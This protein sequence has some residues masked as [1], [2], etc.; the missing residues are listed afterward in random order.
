[1]ITAFIPSFCTGAS[2]PTIPV[3]VTRSRNL[4]R[5]SGASALVTTGVTNAGSFAHPSNAFTAESFAHVQAY[6]IAER[7]TIKIERGA[8]NGRRS[9]S[10]TGDCK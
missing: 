9:Q 3:V 8:Q 7:R 10:P 2:G 5:C 4:S 1:M 6:V